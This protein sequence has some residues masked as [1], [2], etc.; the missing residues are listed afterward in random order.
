MA[1]GTW[2]K[3]L[4]QPKR[5]NLAATTFGPG[6]RR[7]SSH[8]STGCR[9]SRASYTL[10]SATEDCGNIWEWP[11][12][13][14]VWKTCVS[15]ANSEKFAKQRQH[16][17]WVLQLP[18]AQAPDAVKLNKFR[19]SKA[20]NGQSMDMGYIWIHHLDTFRMKTVLG[21][22]P[23]QPRVCAGNRYIC[24]SI[25]G[26]STQ[27]SAKSGS[28][29]EETRRTALTQEDFPTP[30]LQMEEG[31]GM[32]WPKDAN[33][34]WNLNVQWTL[35][36]SNP[37]LDILWH[38]SWSHPALAQ[39]PSTPAPQLSTCRGYHGNIWEHI[40]NPSQLSE[41]WTLVRRGS[42][43]SGHGPPFQASVACHYIATGYN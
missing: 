19:G 36:S 25:V 38:Q 24:G 26:P 39:A 41:T 2:A 18:R 33:G 22:G 42:I 17:W 43:I 29:G 12:H 34:F 4:R 31:C 7:P 9:G 32:L 10:A 15:I 13:V 35:T 37:G 14:N 5:L 21:W 27:S 3:A 1:G 23:S 6:L 16:G 20:H 40:E 30:P 28:L 11:V 8:C